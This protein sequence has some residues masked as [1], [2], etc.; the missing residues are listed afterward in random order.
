MNYIK[1]WYNSFWPINE[2]DIYVKRIG[3]FHNQ[4]DDDS[5]DWFGYTNNN[6]LKINSIECKQ[7]LIDHI[8]IH[9]L[10]TSDTSKNDIKYLIEFGYTNYDYN[11]IGKKII[12]S[13]QIRNNSF[14][15]RIKYDID[16]KHKFDNVEYD[17]LN[18]SPYSDS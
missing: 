1:N 11:L 14:I 4:Y 16:T 9:D 12:T 10:Y 8:E 3:V 5:F 13:G 7:W 2:P 18:S 15:N 6:K 17:E